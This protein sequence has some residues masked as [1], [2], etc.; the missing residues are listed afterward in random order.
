M[1]I[2]WETGLD[3]ICEDEDEEEEE[4]GADNGGDAAAP[5]AAAPPPPAPPA[6]MPEEIDEEGHVEVIPEREA[7]KPQVVVLADVEPEMAQLRL[8]HALMRDY[9]EHLLRMEDDFD[10]LDDDPNEGCTNGDEWFPEDGS[11]DMD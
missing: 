7:L 5:P 8:Y 9:E 10:N 3:R 6:A 4:E 11:N 1:E 2:T